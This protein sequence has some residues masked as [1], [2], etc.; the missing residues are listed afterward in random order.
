VLTGGNDVA[1][2]GGYPA[3]HERHATGMFALMKLTPRVWNQ[4]TD[5]ERHKVDLVMQATLVAS[6]FTTS[7]ANPYITSGQSERTLDGDTNLGRD[8]N[9]TYR[10][11]MVGAM[12][13]GA[14]YFGPAQAQ[15]LLANYD[16]AAFVA[17]VQAAG[18]SNLYQTFNWKAAN[19]GSIAPSGATIQSTVRAGYHYYGHAL[20]DVMGIYGELLDDTYG[21]TVNAGLNGGAGIGGAGKIVSGADTLPNPGAVGMLK[22][23][24]S[25]DAGGA[26]SSAGY[27]YDGFRPHQTNLLV[28]I[29]SGLF[30]ASSPVAQDAAARLEVG[31]TDL[32]YK[33][34]KGYIGYAKGASQGTFS[35]SGDGSSFGFA[36]NR[37][38]WEDVLRPYLEAAVA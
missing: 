30:D 19:P 38:V 10:E 13:V 27:A 16:H 14:A 31:N 33:L 6:A 32:W 36:Y 2:N 4:L 28:M 8:W 37:P 22:E 21:M 20:T 11:G 24:D 35:T 23:F 5:A 29:A 12:L 17:D 34:D 1:A 25:S 18:L 15:A 26:R 9:P 3:Q 7:D